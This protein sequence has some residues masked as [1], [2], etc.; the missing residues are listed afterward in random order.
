[1]MVADPAQGS[2]AKLEIVDAPVSALDRIDQF[3][4]E[5]TKKFDSAMDVC[6][7]AQAKFNAMMADH[8]GKIAVLVRNRVG[9]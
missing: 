6:N 2:A 5:T 7:P 3:E 9:R 4:R 1:M 8:E